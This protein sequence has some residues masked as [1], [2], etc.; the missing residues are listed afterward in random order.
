M[1]SGKDEFMS[2]L[3]HFSGELRRLGVGKVVGWGAKV[4]RL[5]PSQEYGCVYRLRSI[6]HNVQKQ[7]LV[8]GLQH[9]KF[10]VEVQMEKFRNKLGLSWAKPKSSWQQQMKFQLKRGLSFSCS[11]S[12]SWRHDLSKYTVPTRVVVMLV[13]SALPTKV[14]GML[15]VSALPRKV[16]GMLVVSDLPKQVV[17]MQASRQIIPSKSS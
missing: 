17:G 6:R 8:L 15:V 13:V 9:V 2:S 16:L 3:L 10:K 7:K 5:N 12:V 14:V 1:L 4:S 11:C